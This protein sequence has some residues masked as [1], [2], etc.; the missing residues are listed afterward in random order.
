MVPPADVR[1]IE[2]PASSASNVGDTVADGEAD[3][4][5]DVV[6]PGLEVDAV[7]DVPP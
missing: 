6:P 3:G 7:R 5:N 4:P 2:A 1:D